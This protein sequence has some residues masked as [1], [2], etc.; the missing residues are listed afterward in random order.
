MGPRWEVLMVHPSA[1][2]LVAQTGTNWALHLAFRW[3]G[4]TDHHWEL[5]MARC[6]ADSR[7]E[8]LG[9][10]LGKKTV[11]QMVG[12]SENLWVRC[13]EHPT[14]FQKVVLK[15]CWLVHQMAAAKGRLRVLQ[16]EDQLDQHRSN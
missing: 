4:L 5:L 12:R 7:A 13:L 9:I 1:D 11:V 16:M 8:R 10:H 14:E 15:E 6:W 2:Y 3:V